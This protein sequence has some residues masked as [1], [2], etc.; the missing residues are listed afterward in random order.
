MTTQQLLSMKGKPCRFRN[1]KTKADFGCDAW[2]FGMITSVMSNVVS[3]DGYP[4]SRDGFEVK[5]KGGE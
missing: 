1:E 5:I 4:Y 3:V 2:C